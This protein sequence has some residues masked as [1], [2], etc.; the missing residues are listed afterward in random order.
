[1]RIGIF[2]GSFDPVHLGHLIA[3]ET[4]REQAS[5][6]RVLF[7]PAAQPPHKLD[8][9]L[10]P[11]EDRK[12]MLELATGGHPAFGVS[13]IEL[14]RG[15]I[16]YTVETLRELSSLFPA[17]RLVLLLGPDAIRELATWREPLEIAQRAELLTVERVNLDD[18][19]LLREDETL[20]SLL[21]RDTVEQLIE[22]RVRM[23]AVG[24]RATDIR[25]KM[26][27]GSSIRYLVPAAVAAYIATRGLYTDLPLRHP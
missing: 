10:A 19:A 25:R 21:G 20:A 7:I 27:A 26:Q 13:G 5:L 9:T 22:H 24:I 6:D 1:M 11:A 4:A 17:D 12:V 23:P 18:A 15:G 8:S 14:D 3:A 2:G 16:S